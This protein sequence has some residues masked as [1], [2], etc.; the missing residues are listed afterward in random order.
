MLRKILVLC[1]SCIMLLSVTVNAQSNDLNVLNKTAAIEQVLYGTEQTGSLIERVNKL[2]KD[3]YG[4]ET[5]EAL[6]ARLD[7]IYT[8]INECLP[9]EPSLVVKLNAVEWSLTHRVSTSPVKARIENLEMM[10][11]GNSQLGCFND[12]LTKLMNIAFTGGNINVASTTLNKD[13]L[14]K[15]KI[16][17]PLSSKNARVGDIVS[18][19]AAEDVY[20]NSLL[21]LPAGSKG[22][23]KVTKVEQARNFGRDA[24]IEIDFNNV[25]AID[26]TVIDTFVGDK[27]KE[28]TKSLAKAAGATVAGLVILGPV[29][30]IGG[31]FVHGQDIN[32]PVG[33]ELYIQTKNDEDIY[34]L[35]VN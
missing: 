9:S 4:R 28:E 16:T 6:M 22:V 3:I 23:G 35:M 14:I 34:G 30:V 8:Y 29:G 26:N 10:I 13:T 25:G 15:I 31:A 12:R 1:L 2:E 24:K 33:A 5:K 21:V 17:T 20:V 19:E 18:F 11:M 27:A 7:R 32:I